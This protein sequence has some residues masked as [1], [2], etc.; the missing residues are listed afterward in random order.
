MNYLF[1][2]RRGITK[3]HKKVFNCSQGYRPETE[4]K[5]QATKEKPTSIAK[6]S[7][8]IC[9]KI[10]YSTSKVLGFQCLISNNSK[11]STTLGQRIQKMQ[12]K[13]E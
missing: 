11:E 10:G 12:E 2:F 5:K 4:I 6:K 8:G 7:Y 9:S 1:P 3:Y 13:N